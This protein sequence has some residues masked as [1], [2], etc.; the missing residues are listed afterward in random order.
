MPS[1]A[2]LYRH[3]A[4][5]GHLRY[6][7][8]SKLNPNGMNDSVGGFTTETRTLHESRPIV[9]RRFHGNEEI[10]SDLWDAATGDKS[11]AAQRDHV[12][13]QELSDLEYTTPRSFV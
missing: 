4:G 2:V 11:R 8:Q 10:G 3:F 9:A 7:G 13:G 6:S 12:E 5:P 1:I